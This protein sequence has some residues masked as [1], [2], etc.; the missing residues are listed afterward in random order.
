MDIKSI[1]IDNFLYRSQHIRPGQKLD[2]DEKDAPELIKMGKI[3]LIGQKEKPKIIES[4]ARIK[5]KKYDRD[6]RPQN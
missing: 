2:V 6:K 5:R 3:L 4:Q 1:A